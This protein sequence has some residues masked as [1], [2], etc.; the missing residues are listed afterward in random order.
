MRKIKMIDPPKGWLYDFPK[1]IPD[2]VEN[3]KDWLANN[4]Y[5]KKVIDS[6]GESFYIRMWYE[7]MDE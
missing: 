7:E 2:D 6:Y 3:I 1:E 5:P 4:G